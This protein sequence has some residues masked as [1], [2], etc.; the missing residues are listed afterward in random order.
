M[1]SLVSAASLGFVHGGVSID[2]QLAKRPFGVV[3]THAAQ[4]Q[5]GGSDARRYRRGDRR[6]R[7]AELMLP[8]LRPFCRNDV[9]DQKFLSAD[10]ADD[11]AV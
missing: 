2:D 3:T 9:C 1:S 5:G 4:R 6:N 8:P 10:A 11:R 7:V